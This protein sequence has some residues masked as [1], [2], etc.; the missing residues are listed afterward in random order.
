MAIQRIDN[1]RKELLL[2]SSSQV[3]T[4]S[5]VDIGALVP[6]GPYINVMDCD[7]ITLWLK[8]KINSSTG[9]KVKMLAVDTEADTDLYQTVTKTVTAGL[10]TV[11][12]SE[13]VIATNADQLIAVTFAIADQLPFVKFQVLATVVGATAGQLDACGVTFSSNI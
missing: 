13:M 1:K 6:E 9:V 5:Y 10:V 8:L 11:Q 2:S 3:L 7:S 12:P 4:G